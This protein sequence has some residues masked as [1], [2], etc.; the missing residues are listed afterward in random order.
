MPPESSQLPRAKAAP[1]PSHPP[2]PTSFTTQLTLTPHEQALPEQQLRS[3]SSSPT[4]LPSNHARTRTGE[5][6][7]PVSEAVGREGLRLCH[8]FVRARLVVHPLVV[9]SASIPP[10]MRFLFFPRGLSM[11]FARGDAVAV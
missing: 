11:L 10:Y 5:V 3:R 6:V 4:K 8:R 2:L 7:Q 9:L 1:P